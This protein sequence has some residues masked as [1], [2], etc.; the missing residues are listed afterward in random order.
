MSSN[1]P[2]AC[3]VSAVIFGVI[4]VLHAARL[5]T[6]TDVLVG[7][8]SV[9]LTVSWMALIVSGGVAWWLWRVSKSS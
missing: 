7:G 1:A 4:A 8:R 9:P 6:H 5:L 2:R 3:R